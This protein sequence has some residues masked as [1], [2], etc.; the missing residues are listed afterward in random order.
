MNTAKI[1]VEKFTV[2]QLHECDESHAA[3]GILLVLQ[4]LRQLKTAEAFQNS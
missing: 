1:F 2:F 4:Y 3:T